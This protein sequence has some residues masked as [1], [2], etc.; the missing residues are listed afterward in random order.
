MERAFI[1]VNDGVRIVRSTVSMPLDKAVEL[2]DKINAQGKVTAE[3]ETQDSVNDAID[4]AFDSIWS[5][6]T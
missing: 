6:A 4:K 3:I 2:V 1:K 5:P